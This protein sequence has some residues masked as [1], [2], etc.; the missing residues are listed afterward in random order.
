[1]SSST[2]ASCLASS[3]VITVL[4]MVPYKLHS[5]DLQSAIPTI[6]NAY[7]V[8][9]AFYDTVSP[10][11]SCL[12]TS[13]VNNKATCPATGSQTS[14]FVNPANPQ[15]PPPNGFSPLAPCPASS[16]LYYNFPLREYNL[17]SMSFP[18]PN[19]ITGHTN[20][21]EYKL[22]FNNPDD[23]SPTCLAAFPL[24]HFYDPVTTGQGGN[25]CASADTCY[26][27]EWSPYP[28]A[29]AASIDMP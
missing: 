26:Q 4:E 16:S 14:T 7:K 20:W 3:N 24:F 21:M 28:G 29:P 13:T 17:F 27:G 8:Q 25:N 1:M 19:T 11:C 2:T 10:F 5:P 12:V 23:V 15:P 9:A 22:T 6:Q 18:S